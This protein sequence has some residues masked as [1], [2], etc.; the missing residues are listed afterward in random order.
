MPDQTRWDAVHYRFYRMNPHGRIF[1]LFVRTALAGELTVVGMT[2]RF[3]RG[4][5]RTPRWL[6]STLKALEKQF[7]KGT[8]PSPSLIA[9]WLRSR[10]EFIHDLSRGKLDIHPLIAPQLAMIASPGAPQTWA[11]PPMLDLGALADWLNITPGELNWFSHPFRRLATERSG[12]RSHYNVLW[13]P[14][15]TGGGRLLEAPKLRLKLIQRR[16]LNHI[17]NA[18]PPHEAV[19]GF[20]RGHSVQDFIAPHLGK[21]VV[22]RMDLRDFF[23]TIRRAR[24]ASIF[25][26]VGYPESVAQALAGICTT[27]TQPTE[28]PPIGNGPLSGLESL[29]TQKL[30]ATPHLPQGAPS[31]P[32]LANLAAFRMDC[33]LAGLAKSADATYTR[34]ADDL[35]FSG[36]ESFARTVSRFQVTAMTIA[37]EEGF[38]PHA[39]K[40]RVMHQ[41]LRQHAGG[42][43]LNSHPNLPRD[44]WDRLKAT[45]Y[46]AQC[47][48]LESQNREGHPDF[49]AHL[50]GRVSYAA[51]INPNR[52]AKLQSLL[53][54]LVEKA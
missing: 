40:T 21:T 49:L 24:V 15:R 46:N 47:N 38:T 34:Y 13:I 16:I 19:H 2:E 23:P 9:R 1:R 33:R 39:R 48:G 22:L 27:T 6:K 8:R 36:G 42:I 3:G 7:G 28:W 53:S 52:G 31:S 41:G 43:V 44:E 11:V 30:Y 35:L 20:R 32:A 50:T 26:S 25:R 18:I 14:K 37:I 17:L 29:S 10:R 4:L 12:A 54:Q 5:V 45:L 51:S